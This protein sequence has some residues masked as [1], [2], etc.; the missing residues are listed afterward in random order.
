MISIS[1]KIQ[2][3]INDIRS[4]RTKKTYSKKHI[5]FNNTIL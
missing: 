5:V 1:S 2:N 3:R 4:E